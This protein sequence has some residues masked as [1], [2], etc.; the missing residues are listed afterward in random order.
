MVVGYFSDE[1][2]EQLLSRG[3]ESRGRPFEMRAKP[4]AAAHTFLHSQVL[5]ISSRN[6]PTSSLIEII[7]NKL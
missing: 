2:D 1:S 5:P 7:F 3:R 6:L 4:D